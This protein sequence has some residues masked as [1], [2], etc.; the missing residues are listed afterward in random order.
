MAS[1]R[2]LAVT[3]AIACY[4]VA[5]V[6]VGLYPSPITV[7]LLVSGWFGILVAAGGFRTYK[8]QRVVGAGVGTAFVSWLTSDVFPATAALSEA[9]LST[10]LLL[11]SGIM[12]AA[13]GVEAWRRHRELRRES[14]LP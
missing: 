10:H 13:V 6:L 9:S 4:V 8:W 7:G 11:L 12:L 2:V 5:T 14:R 1:K 3:A